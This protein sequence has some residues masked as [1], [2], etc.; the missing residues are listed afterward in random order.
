MITLIHLYQSLLTGGVWTLISKQ[1][2]L[3]RAEAGQ[4]ESHHSEKP[5]NWET[6]TF[7]TR[8]R[9]NKA[10]VLETAAEAGGQHS[11]STSPGPTFYD[12]LRTMVPTNS[13]DFLRVISDTPSPHL[14]PCSFPGRP[15]QC[16]PDRICHLSVQWPWASH[17]RSVSPHFSLYSMFTM[18][19]W[20]PRTHTL[21]KPCVEIQL[22]FTDCLFYAKSFVCI[23]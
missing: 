22:V 2:F 3:S 8:T 17:L 7:Q 9:G 15:T 4:S 10:H 6:N 19:K 12:F 11:L 20:F 23:I 21:K 18:Y 13:E 1:E 16:P 14:T 5:P